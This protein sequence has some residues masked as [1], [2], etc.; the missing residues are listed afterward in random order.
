[1]AKAARMDDYPDLF[2]AKE[3]VNE[4]E[5]IAR[6]TKEKRLRVLGRDGMKLVRVPEEERDRD[7]CRAALTQNGL[8]LQFVPEEKRDMYYCQK[9]LR[10]A[11]MA[12]QYVPMSLR[13]GSVCRLAMRNDGLALQFVPDEER[14]VTVCRTAVDQNSCALQYVPPALLD[15]ALV[16]RAMRVNGRALEYVPMEMRDADICYEAVRTS[17]VALRHV[18]EEL[19]TPVLVCRA[20]LSALTD[21]RRR[22]SIVLYTPPDWDELKKHKSRDE[23]GRFENWQVKVPDDFPFPEELAL[24]PEEVTACLRD[25]GRAYAAAA[26]KP[27][28]ME[29]EKGLHPGTSFWLE[30]PREAAEG[31][32]P[33]RPW[34]VYAAGLSRLLTGETDAHGLPV[35]SGACSAAAAVMDWSANWK[36]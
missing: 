25:L 27:D 19:R 16:R 23:W 24:P 7:I 21:V 34:R 22:A 12:L 8:A 33:P 1:M 15:V 20:M 26:G 18:P 6:E 2:G 32:E 13:S 5:R 31:E 36:E 30:V 10:S 35:Q 4:E 14:D 9:A 29:N 28:F 17:G 3:T 11:G